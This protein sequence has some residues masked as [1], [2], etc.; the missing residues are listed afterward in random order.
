MRDQSSV[1][2]L[3]NRFVITDG[4]AVTTHKD[5]SR[6]GSDIQTMYSKKYYLGPDVICLILGSNSD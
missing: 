4:T 6:R 2:D 5:L 1:K 3:P